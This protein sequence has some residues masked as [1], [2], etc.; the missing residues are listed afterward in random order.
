ME[1]RKVSVLIADDEAHIR[2]LISMIVKSLGAEVVAEAENGEQALELFA[3]HH[4][5]MVLLDIS[6][7]K[8]NGIDTLKKIKASN[9]RTVVIMLTS[10]NTAEMVRECID[11]GAQNYIL[12]NVAANELR[13]EIAATWSDYLKEIMT[14]KPK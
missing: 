8:I 6:M 7:P 11:A 13:Q 5:D 9:A 10:H 1:K 14:G 4:P 3:R 12:K 2:S